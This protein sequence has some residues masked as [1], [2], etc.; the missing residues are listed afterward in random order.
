MYKS[1]RI[2]QNHP[3]AAKDLL[4]LPLMYKNLRIVQRPS[5]CASRLPDSLIFLWYAPW[6]ARRGLRA[7]FRESH[8]IPRNFTDPPPPK[9]N[10]P[11][12]WGCGHPHEKNDPKSRPP[13]KA[14]RKFQGQLGPR[15][16][17]KFHGTIF[18]QNEA[19]RTQK[20]QFLPKTWF[21]YEM[22]VILAF[23]GQI[24]CLGWF[25]YKIWGVWFLGGKICPQDGY[26]QDCNLNC[27]CPWEIWCSDS[28]WQ[29]MALV[30][31]W[32]SDF[33]LKALY[34]WVR[35]GIIHHFRYHPTAYFVIL[36]N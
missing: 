13:D 22:W 33:S 21:P 3:V 27:R 11:K 30:F 28:N 19:K 32:K 7:A 36:E 14:P 34:R 20:Y 9:K 12:K 29:N 1:L 23:F 26:S 15:N 18:M 5:N 35:W 2:V 10:T 8:E 4:N 31:G 17:T 16:P 25:S 6:K 24:G